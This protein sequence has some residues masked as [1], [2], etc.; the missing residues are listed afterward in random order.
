M[1]EATEQLGRKGEEKD[2]WIKEE[3]RKRK[4]R[5]KSRKC[6]KE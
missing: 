4:E 6:R 5:T 1:Q 3:D 2:E